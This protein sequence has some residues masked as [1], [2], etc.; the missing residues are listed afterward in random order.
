MYRR[1][2]G[3]RSEL[4]GYSSSSDFSSEEE[5]RKT[6]KYGRKTG[7]T[8]QKKFWKKPEIK[9]NVPDRKNKQETLIRRYEKELPARKKK[10]KTGRKNLRNT[11]CRRKILQKNSGKSY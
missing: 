7:G 5:E 4:A 10:K 8:R 9:Q 11:F 3:A 2:E 6:P 1:L